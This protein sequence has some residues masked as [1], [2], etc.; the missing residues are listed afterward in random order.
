MNKRRSS[1]VS[2]IISIVI[3]LAFF[4]FDFSDLSKSFNLSS[5]MTYIIIIFGVIF[6]VFVKNKTKNKTNQH[7]QEGY[8]QTRCVE[9]GAELLPYDASCRNCGT[10]VQKEVI[11]DYCGTSNSPNDLMC[12]NCNGLLK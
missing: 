9:C 8:S 7:N 1:K 11:C 2:I 10:V 6:S 3:A 12:K 4:G 5:S